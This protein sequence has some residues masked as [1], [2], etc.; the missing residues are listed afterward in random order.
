MLNRDIGNFLPF[1]EY[2]LIFTDNNHYSAS[3]SEQLG[4]I[5]ILLLL[6]FRNFELD[7]AHWKS[8]FQCTLYPYPTE[9]LCNCPVSCYLNQSNHHSIVTSVI[10][11][12][13]VFAIYISIS[14]ITFKTV[15]L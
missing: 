1:T 4:K 7:G 11:Q 10:S 2:F 6:V 15:S 8:A 3:I 9:S 5:F 12:V 14:E 13:G